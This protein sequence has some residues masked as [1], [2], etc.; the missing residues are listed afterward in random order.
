MIP[1]FINYIFFITM[2]TF[3]TKLPCVQLPGLQIFQN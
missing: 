1:L 2:I 3:V